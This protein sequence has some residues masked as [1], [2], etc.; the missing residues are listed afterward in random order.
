MTVEVERAPPASHA[1]DAGVVHR[2]IKPANLLLD[3]RGNLWVADFGL[4]RVQ[5][6]PGITAP[7]DVVGT[8]R[9]M[10]P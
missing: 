9:Y 2:D 4:A 10:S 5:E 8:L 7:G 3:A 1:S 6:S